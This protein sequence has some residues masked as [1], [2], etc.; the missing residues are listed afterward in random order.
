MKESTVE[1]STRKFLSIE[2]WQ[3]SNF[4]KFVGEGGCDIV[5]WH[6]KRRKIFYIEAKGECSD[7]HQERH[8]G[9]P[10]LLGQII[11]RMDIEGNNLKK[12]RYYGIAV[13]KTWEEFMKR[14]IAKMPYGW[15]LLKL[16]V[17]LVDGDKVEFKNYKY[18][19][20]SK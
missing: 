10:K 18:F 11:S 5:A 17:F 16:K 7:V 15:T 20:K 19:L 9:F 8:N 14:K 12:A 6:P 3:F 1:A 13:P 4:P 2:G